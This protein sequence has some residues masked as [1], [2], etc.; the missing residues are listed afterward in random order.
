MQSRTQKV[1]NPPDG[2]TR[3]AIYGT[4]VL[5]NHC[6]FVDRVGR[7]RKTTILKLAPVAGAIIKFV[8]MELPGTGLYSYF[9]SQATN[10]LCF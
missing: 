3:A 6:S 1:A 5:P 8:S 10:S 7:V 4:V 9:N 2:P